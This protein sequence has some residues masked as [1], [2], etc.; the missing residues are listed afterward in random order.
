MNK[1]ILLALLL[2]FTINSFSQNSKLSIEAGYPLPFG[3]NFI[4][5]N[6][7]GI[8]EVGLNY[9]AYNLNIVNIGFS[10]D[11]NFLYKSDANNAPLS[12]VTVFMLKPKVIGQFNIKSIEK[13]HPQVGIGYS[14]LFYNVE[15]NI[16]P[17]LINNTDRT[18]KGI[19]L[20]LGL[21]YD[22]TQKVYVHAQYDF[23]KI[24]ADNNALNIGYNTNINILKFGL[25]Y[26]I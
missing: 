10:V 6:Y 26:R 16:S 22:I 3:D 8:I 19:N 12:N 20:N 21:L 5:Q 2:V 15:S 4:S 7:D 11:A 25:G 14:F 24:G 9:Q 13:L 18:N 23:I 1:R 17:S